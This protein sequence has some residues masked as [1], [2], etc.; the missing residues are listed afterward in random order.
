MPG[1]LMPRHLPV[2]F[3]VFS[4]RQ[5]LPFYIYAATGRWHF[6][7][8]RLP[9]GFVMPLTVRP[10]RGEPAEKSINPLLVNPEKLPGIKQILI[11]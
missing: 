6:L 11:V 4:K 3:W 2:I 1:M 5:H 9:G 8:H 10:D 7:S